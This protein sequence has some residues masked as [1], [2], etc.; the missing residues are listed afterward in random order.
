MSIAVV[1]EDEL[2][3]KVRLTP[4]AL[5]I[6]EDAFAALAEG[7]VVMPPILR[8]D[9]KE[10][11][12]EMDVKT[13]YVPG[14]DFFALKVSCGF[15]DNPELGLPSLGGL[16]NLLNAKTGQVEAVLLDNGYL[17]DI[18]TALAGAIAA[19]HLARE[20][21][22]TV[23][24]IGTGVQAR[25]QVEALRLVRRFDAVL[26]WGRDA[27]KA[28]QY[29]LE[30]EAKL[31]ITVKPVA[32]AEEAVRAADLVVTTT[33]AR[34]PV[35]KADWLTPGAHVTAMG[36][37]AEDKNELDPNVI[38][39][40]DRYVCDSRAQV[41]RLGELHHAVEQGIVR[42]DFPVTELGAIV[43]GQ[44]PGRENDEQVTVCDLTGTGVQDT[45]IATY[46]YAQVTAA[47]KKAAVV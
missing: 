31:G 29:A 19:K 5:S 18:R 33:P 2:R 13:A 9:V 3:K 17:T 47:A 43:A 28:K 15:F 7:G 20:N 38:A 42:D 23:G 14:M 41:T 6:V 44:E 45:A 27:D 40:A 21:I 12:G 22:E 25:L 8:L 39:R 24:V 36:S 34:E 30:M 4:Q 16:M 46:A 32:T 10:H 35:V 11:N 37:D 26:V 1:S